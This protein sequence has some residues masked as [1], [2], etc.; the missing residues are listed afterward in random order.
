MAVAISVIGSALALVPLAAL[1]PANARSGPEGF[2]SLIEEVSPAVVKITAT[3]VSAPAGGGRTEAPIPER[4][5]DGPLKEFMERFFKDMPGGAIP[6]PD[7]LGSGFIVD[8]AGTV[9]TNHHVVA[10]ARDIRVT[11]KDG[12][13]LA[14]E[15]IGTDDKSDLAVLRIRSDE[16]L[17]AVRWG[18]SDRMR[19]GDW[20]VAVG[21]P[22]GFSGTA[23]AGIVS[24]RGRDLG[25]G[26]YDD[27]IQIDAPINR[28]NSGGPLFNQSGEVIGVNTAIFSPSGGNV[29]IGFAIPSRIAEEVVANLRDKGAV[30]RGWLG[31]VIQPVTTEI[32]ESLDLA[33]ARGVL[34]TRVAPA[35]PAEKA[36]LRQGDVVLAFDGKG[37]R[38]VRDLTRAVAGAGIGETKAIEVWRGA[39]R[40]TLAAEIGQMTDQE[41]AAAVER[42]DGLEVDALG[43]TLAAIDER[44]RARFGLAAQA[45]GVVIARIDEGK[46]AARKGLRPGDVITSIDQSAVKAP[47]DVEKAIEDARSAD[48]KAIL[49]LVERQGQ[50]LFVALKLA[51]A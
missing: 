32:A 37:I 51:D 46:D 34:V 14:A 23:T 48:R 43:L 10:G 28:G 22:F 13:D 4:F 21:S 35:S 41:V 18:D 9:V 8:D 27:F 49:L 24:A 2:A 44:T 39:A 11:L 26:P 36:G 6:Q 42:K 12:R 16:S 15:L 29:G 30:D 7:G 3:R 19:V 45:G 47:A 31:V 20:V 5:R 1:Q 40:L 33:N 50:P 38:G 17:P 25:A